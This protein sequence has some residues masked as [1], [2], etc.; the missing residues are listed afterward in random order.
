MGKFL[1]QNKLNELPPKKFNPPLSEVI[2]FDP[3]ETI[4][5]KPLLADKFG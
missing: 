2:S 3:R 1:R 5:T 4:G